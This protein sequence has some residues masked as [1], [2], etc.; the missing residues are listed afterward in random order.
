MK[1]LMVSFAA[2]VLVGVLFAPRKGSKT[3]KKL[4]RLKNNL[5]DNLTAL[6]QSIDEGNEDIE[7]RAQQLLVD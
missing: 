6:T 4:A 3:R 1:K 2:G 5:Q 7:V